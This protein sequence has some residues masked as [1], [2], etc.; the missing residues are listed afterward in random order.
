MMRSQRNEAEFLM[1]RVMVGAVFLSEGIQ[2]FLFTETLGVG[3]FT[4]I[5]IPFP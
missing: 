3:L 2:K 5:W 4:K 1:I